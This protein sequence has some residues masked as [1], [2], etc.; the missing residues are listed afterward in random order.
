MCILYGDNKKTNNTDDFLNRKSEK[1]GKK[2]ENI[3]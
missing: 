3:A 1:N 2:S